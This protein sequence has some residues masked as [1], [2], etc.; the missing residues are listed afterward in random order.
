MTYDNHGVL[1]SFSYAEQQWTVRLDFKIR[2][3]NIFKQI[4]I[5]GVYEQEVLIIEMPKDHDAPSMMQRSNTR[6]IKF[7]APLLNID[8]VNVDAK[9]QTFPQMEA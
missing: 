7:S 4:W 9:E 8:N 1:R 3:G 6:R 5:V 2:Y